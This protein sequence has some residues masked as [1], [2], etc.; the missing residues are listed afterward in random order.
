[1]RMLAGVWREGV[2][3]IT[4]KTRPFPMAQTGE[5]RQFIASAAL[6]V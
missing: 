6:L 1:M 4:I 2:L 5:E 3:I